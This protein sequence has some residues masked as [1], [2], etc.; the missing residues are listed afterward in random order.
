[1]LIAG[2]N[3]AAYNGEHRIRNVTTNTFQFDV[4]AEAAE[5]ATGAITA[6]IAPLGWEMPFS[7][8]D[9]A[10]YRSRD[11]T[12]N[13]LFLRIDETPL[14]GDGNYG[15][16]PR[17]VLA[18]MWEVLNDV[19]NGKGKAETMWRKAQND[20]ATTR[21]WVLVGDSKRFWLMVNWSESYPNRYAPYF[22]GDYPSFKAGDA[23]DTMIAG[24]YD[25]NINWA[26]PS[27]NLVTDNVYSVGSGVGNTGIWLARGYS[28][29]GGRIN[30]QWVSAPAGGGSTGLGATAVPYPNP[31]DNGIYVMPLMIQE[32]TGPSLRGRLPGL[33]CPLQS[34]PAPEPWRFPGFVI[35]GTQRELLVVNGAASNGN[36]RLAFDLTGPWD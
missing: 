34:I 13:R 8:E 35:D 6:K 15:R 7:G 23:Y 31:A 17:T 33:L 2:A 19:D 27:S 32:Q 28:Q 10:A 26:E 30:A 16:G 1:M 22:F 3:E 25:L 18:Q 36:A 20:N 5:R 14:A 21:P 9:R 11:V 29:L 4:A 24:Y 12:S